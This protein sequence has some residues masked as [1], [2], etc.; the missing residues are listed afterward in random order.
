MKLQIGH[1]YL[2]EPKEWEG[3]KYHMKVVEFSSTGRVSFLWREITCDTK[4]VDYVDNVD[5]VQ[6]YSSTLNKWIEEGSMLPLSIL[7]EEL[8]KME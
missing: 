8:F 5:N 7:P 3:H 2:L 1:E 4:Y 6:Y